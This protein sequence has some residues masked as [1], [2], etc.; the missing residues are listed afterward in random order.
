MLRKL[1]LI[2]LILAI[3]P[4]MCLAEWVPVHKDQELQTAPEVTVLEQ[5]AEYTV[6]KI[7]LSGFNLESLDDK[8]IGYHNVDLLTD[9]WVH[10]PG[11]PAVPY[12]SSVLAIPDN[13]PVSVEVIK[14]GKK[15][16]F[17][18]ISLAPAR[19]SWVE[20]DPETEYIENSD[21]YQTKAM[22]PEAKAV[23]E[24][25]VIFRDFRI[26][27]IAMYPVAYNAANKTLEVVEE[28][29]VKVS[30]DGD[31]PVLNPKVRKSDN[32]APSFGELYRTFITNYDQVLQNRYDGR[33]EGEELMLC[34]MPDEF[35]ESFQS[36][37]DW[38]RQ[39]GVNI[40]VTT[41]SDINANSSNPDIIKNHI[42][43]AYHNWAVPP[44]Y[45]LIIGDK[46]VF[47]HEI[48]SYPDYSFPNE[49]FF[50]EVEG[51]DYFPE[52]MI[53]R[54]TNQGEYRMTVMTNKYQLYE[55]TPYVDDP[56]WFTKGMCCS[57]NAYES[58]VETKRFAAKVMREDGG[59]TV[60]T[61]MSDGNG[62]GGW[63]CTYDVDDIVDRLNEGRSYLNYRGEGW[64]SGWSA[65]CYEFNDNH[66]YSL[67]NSQKFTFVTSIGC[68]VAG[69]HSDGGNCFGEEWIQVGSL[70]NP[71]G[72]IG[73]IGPT[74]NTHTTY[75][76][77]IDKGIYVG[78]FREGMDTPGQAMLRGKLYMFNVFGNDYWVEYHYKVFTVLGDPSIHIWKNTPRHVT[79]DHIT[80]IQVGNNDI[81]VQANYVDDN[82]PV[83][84]RMVTITGPGVFATALTDSTGMAT[85]FIAPEIADTLIVTV[86]GEDVYPEQSEIYIT[87]PEE[88]VEP[89]G[90]PLIADLNGNNDGLINPN[91]N[92]T[93]AFDLKN[94]GEATVVN[95]QA[96]LS[97]TH[98]D[99]QIITGTVNFGNI[100]SGETVSGDPFEV[101]L[102]ASTCP[103]GTEIEF[104]LNVTTQASQWDYIYTITMHGC[105]LEENNY[106]IF[107][108]NTANIDF[109]LNP[110]EDANLY[111]SINNI[112]EDVAPDI[113]GTLSSS[114]PYITIN[115]NS[116]SFGDCQMEDQVISNNDFF[117]LSVDATC[118]TN[119]TAELTLVVNT[120]G[121]LYPY[122]KEINI[123]LPVSKAV[124]QD[125][126]GPDEY[127]YYAYA[128][129]D[130]F[131]DQT[132]TYEWREIDEAGTAIE[133][134]EDQSDYTETVNLPFTYK[135]Y[136]NDYTQLR[137]STD[138]WVAFG[139]GNETAPENMS[140]PSN[141][142]VS[143]MVA[144]FWT[145]LHSLE[146]AE[147]AIY[148]YHDTDLGAFVIEYD[149][150]AHNVMST[151]PQREIFQILL[152]DP[153][154][155]PTNTGDGEIIFQYKDVKDQYSVT[156]GIENDQQ[157]VGLEYLYNSNY[158]PT[159]ARI[160][161]GT[162]IK[163]TTESPNITHI[164]GIDDFVNE[165]AGTL[166]TRVY[167]NPFR[168][169]GFIEYTI[170]KE[171]S[172]VVE[173]FSSTGELIRVLEN[174]RKGAGKHVA[175]WDGKDNS[176][177][178]VATG[179]YLYRVS[180]GE[181][182]VSGK[183]FFVR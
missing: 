101:S 38:K 146:V 61:L 109:R 159:A 110:G 57:N 152:L 85:L 117:T 72:G 15:H 167:P 142:N 107:E 26:S 60:D 123:N 102:P 147:G 94:W 20:G 91:E 166:S 98:P 7:N 162:A 5:S 138:G 97:T 49:D 150:I 52:M 27:R 88:L 104:Q 18:N 172:V 93:L 35:E 64:Y 128:S 29:I 176:G 151:E 116:G 165:D 83:A 95:T 16:I 40:H 130:S 96:V 122:E 182:S 111:I 160:L 124:S 148:Y 4:V 135:Y 118:P 9:T 71:R 105:E 133:I 47:P 171:S 22:F 46:N 129:D 58:Q 8:G 177:A 131:F 14:T 17:E 65:N 108:T 181:A 39:T 62:W 174:S 6:L 82:K 90:E 157:N 86:R 53:G 89:E 121:G 13:A 168:A 178:N 132:P 136:G 19:E 30:Y 99:V 44:T 158:A 68:G 170:A 161:N 43:D 70:T 144:A 21:V 63:G 179:L 100:S 77:R 1:Q 69:F 80:E 45:V 37:A 51:D 31:A 56:D 175:L 74:S 48:V 126:T 12:V 75:N 183:M 155:Y 119:Y 24:D 55:K 125:Y 50:V 11:M 32:I 180:D 139:S 25:P 113:S 163:F 78:M 140:L 153:D 36:Y 33:E 59:F 149:S 84:N 66:V 156:V 3:T 76:N 173:V 106:M 73:F 34:I 143:N 115:D 92:A 112:G 2:V 79:S 23:A 145:D 42:S 10:E 41:F 120:N 137:I 114:D 134:P 127:G 28:M 154:E 87:Q 54:F 164:V 67:N 169:S 103:V 141:D 81:E